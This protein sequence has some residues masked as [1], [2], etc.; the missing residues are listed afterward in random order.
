MD[1][2]IFAIN[3]EL[4]INLIERI[5]DR[6]ARHEQFICNGLIG[7]TAGDQFEHFLLTRSQAR[8]G[9][10]V[11]GTQYGDDSR[12]HHHLATGDDRQCPSQRRHIGQRIFQQIRPSRRTAVLQRLHEGRLVE[13]GQEH[14][15]NVWLCFLNAQR[16]LE[17]VD[18][19]RNL[20]V[21]YG[22]VGINVPYR[23]Q[24]QARLGI[25]TSH[26]AAQFLGERDAE[27]FSIQ[28]FVFDDK[29]FQLLHHLT[30]RNALGGIEGKYNLLWKL[31]VIR[32][33]RLLLFAA[34][35]VFT[36]TVTASAAPTAVDGVLDLRR[37][38]FATNGAVA[39][40]GQ[41]E[42]Y[43]YDL[44]PP[45]E[46]PENGGEVR[47]I[48]VPGSWVGYATEDGIAGADGFATYRLR[49]LVSGDEDLA[50]YIPSAQTTYELWIN[51]ILKASVGVV[52]STPDQG[53][54]AY[55]LTASRMPK[56]VEIVDIVLR[57]SNYHFRE[58]GLTRSIYVDEADRVMLSVQ[59]GFTVGAV[60][61]GAS[62][63]IGIYHVCLYLWQR[64]R[65]SYLYLAILAI[66]IALRT[67]V[68][69]SQL[70]QVW[71]PNMSWTVQIKLEYLTSY[72]VPAT[73]VCFTRRLF[74]L[75]VSQL[76]RNIW[77]VIA[78]V[79]GVITLVT[80][81]RISSQ[82]IPFA[83]LLA[84]LLIAYLGG[85]MTLAAVRRREGALLLLGGA[86]IFLLFSGL[87]LMYYRGYFVQYDL[88]PHGFAFFLLVQAPL[89]AKRS[90]DAF[91]RE[92]ALAEKNAELLKK[93][94][95]QLHQ[96]RK[97]R[98]EMVERELRVRQNIA[99]M[100]HGRTQARLLMAAAKADKAVD[101]LR[102]D[103]DEAHTLVQELKRLIDQVRHE[104]IRQASHS[105]HPATVAAGL[106]PALE[107][108]I[109]NYDEL[110]EVH[111]EAAS[112]V[113]RLDDLVHGTLSQPMR[114]RL[115]RVVE[116]ALNNV[117]RHAHARAI[118]I[119]LTVEPRARPQVHR[120]PLV[121]C[122][123]H[124]TDMRLKTSSREP[125][126]RMRHRTMRRESSC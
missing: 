37:W 82:F 58:G 112:D 83:M 48:D 50:L 73:F 106:I 86:V 79:G 71:P 98:R 30:S 120:R 19:T 22:H 89:L 34:T 5:L 53:V 77:L 126:T 47:L 121:S 122:S 96:L 90:S 11:A 39:L 4:H 21:Q 26:V 85:T 116:E 75:E 25:H 109:K 31:F 88:I 95:R 40:N 16:Q 56:G 84:A 42:F 15:A 61:F 110:Y 55:R 92:K 99:D 44:R 102:E 35:I 67:L 23:S 7:I 38:D 104:D 69:S 70:V 119:S 6:L 72:A 91:H 41:W 74:P 117:A 103:G 45:T 107:T 62:V 65:R 54:P 24:H 108:L 51:G 36:V 10:V 101:V 100:L 94:Q 17:S 87:S 60:L 8:D 68:T 32:Y 78:G 124:T 13:I 46:A 125:T 76:V 97:F 57:V 49:L 115:Y 14:D 63:I 105:L 81:P 113:E 20:N 52:S 123:V 111:W 27:H 64:D 66:A 114:F 3:A 18:R 43:W 29:N 2:R 12:I 93:M 33:A 80:P 118:W 59:R 1:A 28:R 9:R